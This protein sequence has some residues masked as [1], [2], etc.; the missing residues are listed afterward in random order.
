MGSEVQNWKPAAVKRLLKSINREF[1][2]L[3][4]SQLVA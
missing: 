2:V 4:L 3:L 1:L